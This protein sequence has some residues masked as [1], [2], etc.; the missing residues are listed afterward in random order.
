M[1]GILSIAEVAAL[2]GDPAR[3][4]ILFALKDD[5]RVS[6]GELSV[7]AGIA[8]STTSEHLAKLNEAGLVAMIAQGRKRYYSLADP[9]VA[10][11][12]E[13]VE[14]LAST[15]SKRN[16]RPLRWDQ[17]MIHA[18]SCLDHLAG[19]LGARL[20]DAATTK[21]FISNFSSGPELTEKG[22]AWLA[23]LN[24]DVS[25]LKSEPRKFLRLCPDWIEESAHIGGAVGAA[26]LRGLVDLG[27]LRRVHGSPKVLV[28]P[29]G[30]SGFRAQFDLDVRT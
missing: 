3:A 21:G 17:G 16:P 10:E 11:V 7:I 4:N 28:T 25:A 18:R 5:G 30:V 2:I 19:R 24:I 23:S 27:W 22:A 9:A 1:F 8:P 14:G 15:L 29:K 13:A 6:A 20:A 26:M 12:L